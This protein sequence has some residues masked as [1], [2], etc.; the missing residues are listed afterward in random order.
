MARHRNRLGRQADLFVGF[1]QRRGHGI[2]IAGL[3]PPARKTDLPRMI[4]Q[5]CRPL[6]QQQV[7]FVAA[8]LQRQQHRRR[9]ERFVEPLL[10]NARRQALECS[11]N[12]ICGRPGSAQPPFDQTLHANGFRS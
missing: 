10:G 12:R 8:S 5:V 7:P 1:A 3:Y 2:R 4:G 6:R 9:Y 11:R